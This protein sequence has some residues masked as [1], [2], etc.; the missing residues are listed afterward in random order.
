MNTMLHTIS[1][2]IEMC[3]DYP[4]LRVNAHCSCKKAAAIRGITVEEIAIVEVAIR[5]RLSN[6]FGR[7]MERKLITLA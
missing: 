3:V 1:Y 5:T 7:L 4:K 2:H 6:R